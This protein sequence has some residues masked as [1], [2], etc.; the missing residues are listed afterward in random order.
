MYVLTRD[1]KKDGATFPMGTEIHSI[2][3]LGYG[4]LFWAMVK[5]QKITLKAD[6]FEESL[7]QLPLTGVNSSPADGSAG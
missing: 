4:D 2:Y 6:D 5:R 3:E 1:I 7:D